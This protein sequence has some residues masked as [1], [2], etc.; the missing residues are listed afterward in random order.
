M[1]NNMLKSFFDSNFESFIEPRV[2]TTHKILNNENSFQ[3]YVS[4]PGLT[5]NDLKI[6]LND[7]ILEISFKKPEKTDKYFFVNE[8][9][10]SFYINDEIDIDNISAKVINGILEIELPKLNKKINK[11][12]LIEIV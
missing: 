8:F 9:K 6:F 7:D 3:I 11:E 4:V 5:K 10:K 2:T 12:R 1:K